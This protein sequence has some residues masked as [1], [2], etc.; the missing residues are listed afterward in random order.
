MRHVLEIRWTHN[1]CLFIAR[2]LANIN[3][4]NRQISQYIQNNLIL[5][6]SSKL[7]SVLAHFTFIVPTKETNIPQVDIY[8]QLSVYYV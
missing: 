7:I 4:F 3:A 5:Q 1:R 2:G 6:F 8:L